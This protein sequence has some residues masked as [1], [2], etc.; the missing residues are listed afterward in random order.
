MGKKKSSVIWAFVFLVLFSF[1][2]AASDFGENILEE[3]YRVS[4]EIINR[5]I[6][7]GDL[8]RDF[9][10]IENLGG[11]LMEVSFSF[12]GDIAEIV[13]L[14]NSSLQIDSGDSE[15]VYFMI[16]GEEGEYSGSLR[17]TGGIN[18][19]IPVEVFVGEVNKTQPYLLDVKAVQDFYDIEKNISFQLIV[20]RLD[21]DKLNNVSFNYSILDNE[22]VVFLDEF[23]IDLNN[24]VSFIQ[25]Y[26]V[27][28]GLGVGE[29]ILQVNSKQG[30][31]EVGD[32]VYFVLGYSFLN[33][34][35]FGFLRVWV[36]IL[37]ISIIGTGILSFYLI[38][39]HIESKKKY[40]MKLDLKTLPQKSKENLFV[41]KIAETNHYAYFDPN[42]FTTHAI[43]AGATGGGKSITAQVMIEECLKKNIAVIVFD[44][45]AQWSGMLRKCTDKKMTGLYSKFGMKPNEAQAFKGNVRMIKDSRQVIDINKFINPGQIQIF[46]LNKLDPSEMDIF[47][48]S[49][50]RQI[51]KSDPKEYPAL[52]VLLVFDEVHRLLPKF[53]GSG[54][55]FLQIERGCREFRKWGLGIMLVSQVLADFVGEIKANI[56]TEVQMRTRD[57]GD[58]KRIENKNGEEFLQ[59]LVKA[60]AGFGMFSNPAYNHAQPYF[61]QF[62]P[63]LHNTKRLTDE[64]LEQYNKYNDQ[65][66]DIE[67]QIEKLEEEK[68]DVFDLK[69]ELKLVKDKIMS[70][71][72][73]V[74]EIY[75]EGLSP[76]LKKE[77]EKLG[78][79]PPERKIELVSEEEIK[80]SIEEAKKKHDEEKEKEGAAA[81]GEKKQEQK[82]EEKIVASLTF[83]NG[84]MISSLKELKEYLPSMD[85]SIFK[86][87]VNDEKNDIQKWVAEQFG[88]ELGSKLKGKKTKDEI[89]QIVEEICKGDSEEDKE[90]KKEDKENADGGDEEKS[91]EK[92]EEGEEDKED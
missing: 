23:V 10:E 63:I 20:T 48:A 92:K 72:F 16:T 79:K 41:G 25:S 65:V 78:K 22:S 50:I 15:K 7:P 5:S 76:R 58:L 1:V 66:D 24:S 28:E 43:V 14:E 11:S 37:I 69:M 44:P 75:L 45:T 46:S 60:S 42:K 8:F 2:S 13:E 21:T 61:I 6:S 89:Q 53:G 54:E 30:D 88:E 19:D 68:V 33:I 47:V 74:V 29:Y 85:N 90:E 34:P 84:A 86:V 56:S 81:E 77:W 3:D 80:K 70:G 18:K 12:S 62:R 57:E 32:Q 36:L 64:E 26:D 83:D 17:L 52:K 4:R 55:G 9:V 59:S 49:I 71:S 31:F 73:S 38:K 91:E 27:P 87:H 67:F 82:L 39:R 40:Q 51:F 35:L